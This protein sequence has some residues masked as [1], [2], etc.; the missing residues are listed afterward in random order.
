M[1]KI[2]LFGIWVLIKSA[3]TA[4]LERNLRGLSSLDIFKT[5]IYASLACHLLDGI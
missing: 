1:L 4:I 3:L 5:N 2:Y